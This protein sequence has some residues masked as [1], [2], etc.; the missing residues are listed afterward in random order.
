MVTKSTTAASSSNS[1]SNDEEH[2]PL[3]IRPTTINFNTVLDAWAKS[4]TKGSAIRA[5]Q[6]MEWMDRLYREGNTDV[7]PDTITFNGVIDAWARSHDRRAPKRAEEIL[8]HMNQ[9]YREGNYDVRPDTYTYNTV[10]NCWAKSNER[11]AADRAEHIL[12]IMERR[13]REEGDDGGSN[14]R[15]NTRTHTSVIDA[16]AKSGEQGAAR[17]AEAILKAM[18]RQ[19]QREGDECDVVPNAHTYNAVM[20]AC[21]FTANAKNNALNADGTAAWNSNKEEAL[22]IAFRVFDELVSF[23]SNNNNSTNNNNN[24]ASSTTAASSNMLAPDAYTY[25]IMISVCANLISDEGDRFVA[26]QSLF[27]RCRADGYVNDFVLRKLRQA[28]SPDQFVEL[29]SAPCDDDTYSMLSND[30]NR[31]GI[32]SV[33]VNHVRVEDLPQSWTR[34]V[35]PPYN[36]HTNR[37]GHHHHHHAR[38]NKDRERDNHSHSSNTNSFHHNRRGQGGGR[39][40]RRNHPNHSNRGRRGRR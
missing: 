27:E 20:N 16:W 21:A 35:Q 5:E 36:T 22:T 31:I 17:R 3:Q 28:V 12:A 33:N 1:N 40:G 9:L 37:G 8:E 39:G 25:T 38:R 34:K 19:H 2:N 29:V 26:V 7:K 14:I 32:G 15:P 13:Y 24:S 30:A 11:G 10:I 23:S 6:I 4:N 18:S